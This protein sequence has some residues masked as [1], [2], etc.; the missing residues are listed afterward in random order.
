MKYSQ[1]TARRP[2][3]PTQVRAS[4]RSSRQLARTSTSSPPPLF[5]RDDEEA[6]PR[7]PRCA[8][9]GALPRTG[10]LT[11][12][13]DA[14]RG[15]SERCESGRRDDEPRRRRL[16]RARVR[17]AQGP[18]PRTPHASGPSA[19]TAERQP[20]QTP[21][22]RRER[23][24]SRAGQPRSGSFESCASVVSRAAM[25]WRRRRAA[26]MASIHPTR[27]ALDGVNAVELGR[28]LGATG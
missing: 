7:A 11:G 10:R 5:P 15:S 23:V 27:C 12:E 6:P 19:A 24:P 17:A 20:R 4:T 28:G 3:G 18:G 16:R 9:A 25:S 22:I 2:N 1:P 8:L 14:R 13:P 21:L 26:G